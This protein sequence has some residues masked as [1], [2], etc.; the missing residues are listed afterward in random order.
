MQEAALLSGGPPLAEH[1]FGRAGE[2]GPDCSFSS[3]V[4]VRLAQE[5]HFLLHPHIQRQRESHCTALGGE[6]HAESGA[7]GQMGS[8]H[9]AA[10]T[11]HPLSKT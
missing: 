8:S 3:H 7:L 5:V 9:S 4:W 1:P 10:P 2:E 6:S 11:E